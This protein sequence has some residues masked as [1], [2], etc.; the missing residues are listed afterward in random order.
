MRSARMRMNLQGM[1]FGRDQAVSIMSDFSGYSSMQDGSTYSS[2]VGTQ[3]SSGVGTQSQFSSGV[4]TQNSMPRN[5]F[6]FNTNNN[7]FSH[8]GQHMPQ[9]APPLS[10][11]G[12]N[13]YDRRRFFAKMK[14]GPPGNSSRSNSQRTDADGMPDIHMVDSA[15]SLMS[16]LSAHG[17]SRHGRNAAAPD[18]MNI[19]GH[20]FA[21]LSNLSG[22]RGLL[23]LSGHGFASNHSGH[24]SVNMDNTGL[25]S[26]R[27]LMS[28]LSKI[29]DHSAGSIFSD[30]AKKINLPI[31]S[32]SNR[33]VAMSEVSGVD[34]EDESDDDEFA[35][36]VDPGLANSAS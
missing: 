17:A 16:N 21:G 18:M 1:G 31:N 19:S 8:P 24:D 28:G 3:F 29:S 2:G 5:D 26:R 7:I 22:H 11:T 25:G 9:L 36:D 12:N 35:Y 6:A 20:G 14:L 30:L 15:F 23:N 4:G 27:S 33:S 32:M 10:P 13:S 34:E